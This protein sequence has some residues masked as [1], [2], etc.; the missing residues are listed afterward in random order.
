VDDIDDNS[1]EEEEEEKE[2]AI[3]SRFKISINDEGRKV[4]TNLKNWLK[5]V[6]IE[7]KSLTN[8]CIALKMLFHPMKPF[9][10]SLNVVIKQ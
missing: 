5:I 4:D 2:Q 10:K 9:K 6:P 1:M 3:S 8:D 7:K